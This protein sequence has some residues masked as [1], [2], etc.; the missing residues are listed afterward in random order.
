M[1]T[2]EYIDNTISN[3]SNIMN[4]EK[5]PENTYQMSGD[6]IRSIL[7]DAIKAREYAEICYI[8]AKGIKSTRVIGDII[9]IRTNSY[10]RYIRAFCFYRKKYRTFKVSNISYI[11]ILTKEERHRLPSTFRYRAK[12]LLIYLFF[13][14]P[15][16]I[17]LIII[18]IFLLLLL[19]II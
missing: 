1:I 7:D 17:A 15:V 13:K 3:D 4:N 11:R 2:K 8:N 14:T 6:K 19:L 12:L 18:F 9:N 10:S 16:G 5:S